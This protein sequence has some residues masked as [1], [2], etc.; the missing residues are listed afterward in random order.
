[1]FS[2][3]LFEKSSVFSDFMLEMA[4][5]GIFPRRLL[6]RLRCDSTGTPFW[7]AIEWIFMMLFLLRSRLNNC[8]RFQKT[9]SGTEV[10]ELPARISV[11]RELERLFRSNC[12][13]SEIRL[14]E[15]DSGEARN[16]FNNSETQ[17]WT[18]AGSVLFNSSHYTQ[19]TRCDA[20][21]WRQLCGYTVS[22]L[23]VVIIM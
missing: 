4:I 13:M 14:S 7:K 16:C 15:T 2:I 18:L 11:S 20:L 21:P 1:M 19:R 5:K 6:A 9:P 22:E 17:H 3:L 8:F 23:C 10:M 12:S